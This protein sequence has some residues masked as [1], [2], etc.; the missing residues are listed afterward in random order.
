MYT[1]DK[2]IETLQLSMD[3]GIEEL[4]SNIDTMNETVKIVESMEDNIKL[5]KVALEEDRVD[6]ITLQASYERYLE[7]TSKLGYDKIVSIENNNSYKESMNNMIISSE[8]IVGIVWSAVEEL[9]GRIWNS[10]KKLL[11]NISNFFNLQGNKLEADRKVLNNLADLNDFKITKSEVIINKLKDKMSLFLILGLDITSKDDLN[12]YNDMVLGLDYIFNNKETIL[13]GDENG[14]GNKV[15]Y[16]KNFQLIGDKSDVIFDNIKG[17]I[18]KEI[19]QGKT[20]GHYIYGFN[21]TSASLLTVYDNSKPIDNL[22]LMAV[23]TLN[24]NKSTF[25]KNIK[26]DISVLN[27]DVIS[28]LLDVRSDLI[29]KEKDISKESKK[30]EKY[31]KEMLKINSDLATGNQNDIKKIVSNNGNKI[32]TITMYIN[33]SLAKH[34][35]AYDNLTGYLIKLYE[36]A[37]SKAK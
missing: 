21:P 17:L 29:D 19:N 9:F 36:E 24:I 16:N 4:I 6:E 3:K 11:N 37:L 22:K 23:N 25:D 33:T 12:K 26:K 14:A 13:N 15:T 5:S 34:L 35:T 27:K 7:A 8:G 10:I 2:E 30:I 32:F 28:N 31:L 18:K 20:I 1:I